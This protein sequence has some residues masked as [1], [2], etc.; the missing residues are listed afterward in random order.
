M[1]G[2]GE[3]GHIVENEV[4]LWAGPYTRYTQLNSAQH[5]TTRDHR[6]LLLPCYRGTANPSDWLKTPPVKEIAVGK[7]DA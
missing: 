2:S 1:A 4:G 7:P 5:I 6:P 3:W